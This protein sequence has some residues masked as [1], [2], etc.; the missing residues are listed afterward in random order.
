MDGAR[1]DLRRVVRSL[2]QVSQVDTRQIRADIERTRLSKNAHRKKREVEQDGLLRKHRDIHL[3]NLLLS[4]RLFE[5]KGKQ[6]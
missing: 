3:P 1:D 2:S 6:L 4:N 5:G